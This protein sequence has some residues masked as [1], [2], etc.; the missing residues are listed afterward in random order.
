MKPSALLDPGFSGMPSDCY[1]AWFS[2][3]VQA[4]IQLR[5]H[6][7]DFPLM[8]LCW[9]EFWAAKEFLNHRQCTSTTTTHPL[10]HSIS[11]SKGTFCPAPIFSTLLKNFDQKFQH[12]R[13]AVNCVSSFVLSRF[14]DKNLGKCNQLLPL[15]CLSPLIGHHSLSLSLS[16]SSQSSP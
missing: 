6:L 12:I 3:L 9:C 1:S 14:W 13:K 2:S 11:P 4:W 5:S 8:H 16:L 10:I 7:K 15:F